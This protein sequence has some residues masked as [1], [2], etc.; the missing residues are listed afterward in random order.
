MLSIRTKAHYSVVDRLLDN[1]MG[2]HRNAYARRMSLQGESHILQGETSS[3]RTKKH[4]KDPRQ[5]YARKWLLAR[6]Y[7]IRRSE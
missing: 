3:K 7:W 6:S 2:I 5:Y 4:G 1:V